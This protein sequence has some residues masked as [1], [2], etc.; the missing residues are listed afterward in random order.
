[1]SRFPSWRQRWTQNLERLHLQ[2]SGAESTPQMAV[3]GVL[4]GLLA[5][6]VVVAFRIIVETAQHAFLPGG[7][8]ENF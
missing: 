7:K 2:L 3:L 4:T 8:P 5:G 1:M 6:V